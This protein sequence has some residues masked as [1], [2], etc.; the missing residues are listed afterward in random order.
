MKL[1]ALLLALSALYYVPKPSFVNQKALLN[2]FFYWLD[3]YFN[4]GKSSHALIIWLLGALLPAFL[5]GLL[6]IYFQKVHVLLGLVFSIFLLYVTLDFS[7]FGVKQKK[8]ADALAANNIAELLNI[9]KDSFVNEHKLESSNVNQ[10]ASVSIA[11]FFRNAHY[12]LF[13]LITWFFVF[14]AAGLVLF[15][16][17][18][19]LLKNTNETNAYAKM[20]RSI[21]TALDWLPSYLTATCFAVV[22]DFEDAV[23]CWRTQLDDCTNKTFA[24]ILASGA[25]AL[26]VKLDLTL[27]PLENGI[28]QELGIGDLADNDYLKSA[29]GLVWR[30]LILLLG[31]LFLL[32]FAHFLGS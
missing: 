19:L 23:Y 5:V 12:G 4:G 27:L 1:L 24:N 3:H 28:S 6:S 20:S 26:E 30:G 32:A 9:D 18:F 13:A 16:L 29:V 10:I 8:I 11:Y 31:S 22:G 14:G 21:F 2:H 7:N 25:G 17:S 15:S